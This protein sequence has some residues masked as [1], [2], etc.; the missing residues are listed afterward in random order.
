MAD[1][2]VRSFRRTSSRTA[3]LAALAGSLAL[4]GLGL[5]G[6]A[7]PSYPFSQPPIDV[8]SPL[9]EDLRK[10]NPAGAAYPSFVSMPSAPDDVRPASAWTRNIFDTLRTRRE[11]QEMSVIYPQTLY[12][13]E[14]FAKEE[15][16]KAAAPISPAEAAAQSEKTAQFAKGQRDRAKAPSPAQ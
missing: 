4:A 13:T 14:A 7:T 3:S 15:R 2:F 6:C 5:C 12:G 11:T 1:A 9:A 8:T 16:S 10:T